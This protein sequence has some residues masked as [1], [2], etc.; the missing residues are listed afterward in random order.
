[1]GFKCKWLGCFLFDICS[2]AAGSAVQWRHINNAPAWVLPT[3]VMGC[4]VLSGDVTRDLVVWGTMGNSQ[5][6]LPS[7]PS[8]QSQHS[9][10]QIW[11]VIYRVVLSEEWGQ[12]TVHIEHEVD[13]SAE[14]CVFQ[15]SGCQGGIIIRTRDFLTGPGWSLSAMLP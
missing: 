15:M 4:V 11:R 12:I 7:S 13:Q 2:W 10:R 5:H 8:S 9:N 14:C 6:Q 1:M 3:L